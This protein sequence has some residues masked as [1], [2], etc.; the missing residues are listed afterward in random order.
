MVTLAVGS[1]GGSPYCRLSGHPY[2]L[3]R[4]IPSPRGG[5]TSRSR[6]RPTGR[7]RNI[8][9]VCIRIASRLTVSSRL[10][11]GRLAWPRKP[12]FSAGAFLRPLSL[13]MPTFSFPDAPGSLATSLPR[14]PECSPTTTD[15]RQ[16]SSASAAVLMPDHHPRGSARPVSCYALFE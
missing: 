7:P 5:F 8:N 2:G 13:L 6:H 14:R 4:G 10:T 9:R 3:Q 12:W 1:P 11:R 16:P 15:S